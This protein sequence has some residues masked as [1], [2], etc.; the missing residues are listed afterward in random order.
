MEKIYSIILLIQGN[1]ILSTITVALLGAFVFFAH[2][3][4]INAFLRN[5]NMVA[6]SLMLPPIAMVITKTIATNFFL[7]LGMIG[8]LSIIRYRTPVKSGYELAL[9]FCLI[10]IGVVG[11]VNLVDAIGL[12]VFIGLL[13]PIIAF[14]TKY[15]PDIVRTE[16]PQKTDHVDVIIRMEGH[17][18]KISTLDPY[19]KYLR[20]YNEV[21]FDGSPTTTLSMVFESMEDALNFK[22]SCQELEYISEININSSSV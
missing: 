19:Y 1:I 9:L 22:S 6:M 20:S 2:G 15:F 14:A 18:E 12:T 5:R 7:S 3:F 11:G 16:I 13:A 21:S 10:T 17:H 4:T 8:A